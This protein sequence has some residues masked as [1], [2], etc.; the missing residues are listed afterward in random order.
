MTMQTNPQPKMTQVYFDADM[1][2]SL[3]P[4]AARRQMTIPA[5]LQD[6]VE[7]LANEPDLV[8][9]VLDDDR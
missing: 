1:L 8:R 6:L 4:A 2:R 7:V 3:R 5:L 9:A